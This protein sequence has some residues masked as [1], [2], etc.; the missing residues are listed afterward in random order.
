MFDHPLIPLSD[1]SHERCKLV[2][3]FRELAGG[4]ADEASATEI[5][6]GG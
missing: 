5:C 3:E 2:K 1:N 6:H 4:D